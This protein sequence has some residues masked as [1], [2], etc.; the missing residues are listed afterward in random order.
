MH[1][2]RAAHRCPRV[3]WDAGK[4]PSRET[5]AFASVIELSQ[6]I[7]GEIV[8]D[9]L[10]DTLMLAA[11]Q[12]TTAGRGLLILAH[13]D[14]LHIEAE[15]TT[16][17]E[18]V[19]VHLRH[20]SV[21]P[22]D[23]PASILHH[24]V[25]TRDSVL[26]QDASAA[27][28]FSLDEY[29]GQLRARSM[30]CLPLIKRVGLVGVLYLENHS[31]PDV[32]TPARIAAVKQLA[33]R[34]QQSRVELQI[35]VRRD[36]E[37]FRDTF[38]RAHRLRRPAETSCNEPKAGRP[39]CSSSTLPFGTGIQRPST[40][41]FVHGLTG[42]H[43]DLYDYLAEEVVGELDPEIRTF[44]MQTS[45]LRVITPELAHLVTGMSPSDAEGMIRTVQQLGLLDAPPSGNSRGYRYHP[46]VREFL[47]SRL[48]Q[49][50][51]EEPVVQ[52]HRR[53]AAAN[54]GGDWRT[55]A[56]HYLE[57]TSAG[58]D[59]LQRVLLDS[60]GQIMARG[61]FDVAKAYVDRLDRDVAD[62]A[63]NLF[64][65]QQCDLDRGAHRVGRGS[66]SRGLITRHCEHH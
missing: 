43:G 56:H 24:V 45:I 31:T 48:R 37:L 59:D 15:A 51:G 29:I 16:R 61:E 65:Y 17:G 46:L 14:E 7:S 63:M 30:L 21:T 19:T 4:N 47:E 2:R 53:V 35:Q 32:F 1:A 49:E 60:A 34:R 5:G 64:I 39:H 6:A 55:A 23:M 3:Y 52:L 18:T 9:R 26:V 42:A 13:L 66:C 11:L 36:A 40:A 12:H 38:A 10:I 27:G 8:L 22:L 50:S 54:E 28:P 33:P 57:H 20:A 25:R 62:P 41:T 58:P 44:L